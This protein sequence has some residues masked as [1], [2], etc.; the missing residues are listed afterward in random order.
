MASRSPR[1]SNRVP[2]A[3]VSSG[4]AERK[5]TTQKSAASVTRCLACLSS[6]FPLQ[7]V[8]LAG[9]PSNIAALK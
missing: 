6:T 7:K 8:V 1:A 9:V 2:L 5:S 3:G 4:R